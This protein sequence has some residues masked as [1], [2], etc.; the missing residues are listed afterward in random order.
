[1]GQEATVT[2][3]M[4]GGDAG[5]EDTGDLASS[6]VTLWQR[7]GGKTKQG[8]GGWS[9]TP[10][11]SIEVEVEK[12]VVKEV[13]AEGSGASG[14]AGAAK[15]EATPTLALVPGSVLQSLPTGGGETKGSMKGAVSGAKGG[16]GGKGGKGN[17]EGD[18]LLGFRPPVPMMHIF[19]KKMKPHE[20]YAG[21][22]R[23]AV[24]LG[25]AVGDGDDR[26]YGH[27]GSE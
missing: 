5:R 21:G 9:A 4:G 20:V 1:M 13:H 22:C 18:D 11:G 3:D 7:N 17:A 26:M 19:W 12:D 2:G 16:K 6:T 8:R 25:E 10:D 14:A 23:E 27:F 15:E 24:R